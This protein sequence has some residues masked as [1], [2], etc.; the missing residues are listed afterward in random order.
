MDIIL[1]ILQDIAE[2]SNGY[3]KI[4]DVEVA[5]VS[6]PMIR[7][8]LDAGK[9]EQIRKGLYML[10]D[11]F[12]DDFALLQ[13]QSSKAVYSYGTALYLWGLSDRTPHLFD[14]TFPRGTNVSRLKKIM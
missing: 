7:K 11:G 12:A 10:T 3:I 1:N 14:M 13:V 5:G 4:S 9:L 6:R 2:S 8:Y